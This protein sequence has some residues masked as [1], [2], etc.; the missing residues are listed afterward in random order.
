MALPNALGQASFRSPLSDEADPP[1][2]VEILERNE[3]PWK[4]VSPETKGGKQRPVTETVAK[5]NGAKVCFRFS[6]Y[7]CVMGPMVFG[8][9]GDTS[10]AKSSS[11][12]FCYPISN[13]RTLRTMTCRLCRTPMPMTACA[14]SPARPRASAATPSEDSMDVCITSRA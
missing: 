10:P 4:K 14:P 6:V 2:G 1:A 3:R 7:P 9:E 11:S 12:P 5:P 8:L 13:S